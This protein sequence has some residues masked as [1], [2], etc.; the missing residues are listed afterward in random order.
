MFKSADVTGVISVKFLIEF[1]TR[2]DD[3]IAVKNYNEIACVDVGSE[4]GLI[5]P[6]KIE[7][8]CEASLPSDIPEA[9]TTY[10]FLSTELPFAIKVFI[11]NLQKS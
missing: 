8:T 2:K 6:L 1:L 7:A 9:S 10:H 11:V 4:D 3:L 5:L